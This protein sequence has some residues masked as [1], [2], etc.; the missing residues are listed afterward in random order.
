MCVCVCVCVCGKGRW[1]IG[2][3]AWRGEG[4]DAP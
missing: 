4:A 3:Y 1:M 2:V